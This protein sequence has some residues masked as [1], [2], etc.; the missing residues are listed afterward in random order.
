MSDGV[1]GMVI[2]LERDTDL[3]MAQLMPLSLASVKSRL[4]LP[5]WY[6]L[7][8]VVVENGPLNACVYHMGTSVVCFIRDTH[9]CCL[10]F[11]FSRFCEIFAKH[12]QTEIYG[13]Q[14]SVHSV[15]YQQTAQF[16]HKFV[17]VA[18]TPSL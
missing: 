11:N 15:T 16:V 9:K 17:F 12:G 18:S 8:W 2:C 1:H 5:F 3:Y 10:L 7:T 4:V 6:R 13:H 14:F